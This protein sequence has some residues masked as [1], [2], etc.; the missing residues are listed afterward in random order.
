MESSA[1]RVGN[2]EGGH[3]RGDRG[4]GCRAWRD[5]RAADVPCAWVTA[6]VVVPVRTCVP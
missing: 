6:R 1:A 4:I 2:A 3:F 5:A